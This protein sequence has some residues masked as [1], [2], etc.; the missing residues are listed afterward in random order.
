MDIFDDA[1]E[2]D[3]GRLTV[4]DARFRR[5]VRA[6]IG[7]GGAASA[8]W[9]KTQAVYRV[10]CATTSFFLALAAA[11][12]GT[13]DRSD[14]RDSGIHR[15][16][17]GLKLLAFAGLQG[18]T[19]CWASDESMEA[20][21]FCAR[22]G[23]GVFLVIQMII[24][25]DLAF[26]W[27]ESWASG[28]HWGWIAGL[29]ASTIGMYATAIAL[30]VEMYAAYAPNREC[31]QNVGMITSVAVLCVVF[32]VITFHPSSRE[33][34]LLPSAAVTLYCAYLCYSALASEPSTYACRPRTFADADEA[35]RKPANLVTTM[36][37]LASVVY[38]AVRAGESNFWDMEPSSEGGE[39]RQAL[40]DGE[41]DEGDDEEGGD[42][43]RG[44][45]KY[46]YSFFHLIFA[47]AA[48]YTS[49]L[50]TGWGARRRDDAE[51]VGNDWTS[52]WVKF[53]SAWVAGA[54][55]AWCLI[56]PALFPDREF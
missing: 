8:A 38:A 27:S 4:G 7:R 5:R 53:S 32:T 45:V 19:M 55:Y 11:L 47:L 40:D 48:M 21:A 35:L 36:F 22:L 10:S 29:L 18:M 54:L 39:L 43:A 26:A 24:V 9:F 16:N 30:F 15:G 20:Y 28:E 14:P 37:T 50:L 34:S 31:R 6:G 12:L 1:V 42:K 17:W 46:S 44:P 13:K 3:G 25:L 33:G 56:A 23:S 2:V 52:V 49:M 51:A 41:D